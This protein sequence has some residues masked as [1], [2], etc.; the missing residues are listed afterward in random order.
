MIIHK[1][2]LDVYGNLGDY[3][4]TKKRRVLTV[5]DDIIADMEL[6][7]RGRNLIFHLFLHHNLILKCLKLQD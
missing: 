3:N 2:L 4:P 5:L 1:Q 7:L 6:L